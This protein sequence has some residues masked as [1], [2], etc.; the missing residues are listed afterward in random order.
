MN[1]YRK[2]VAIAFVLVVLLGGSFYTG[3]RVGE[4]RVKTVEIPSV[5]NKDSVIPVDSVDFSPFWKVWGIINDKFVPTVNTSTTT[6]QQRVWGAI[7]GLANSLKDPYTVFLPPVK[8]EIFQGDVRGNFQGVGMEVGLTEGV[9]TVIAPLKDTPAYKAGLKPGDKIVKIDGKSTL[10]LSTE[11]SVSL[12]RGEKG[13]TVVFSIVR[14]GAKESFD[15]PVVRDVI[16]IPTI[17]TTLRPDGIFVIELYSFSADSPELFRKALREFVES[18]TDK[19]LLD[20]R[21]NPGGYLEAAIDMASWFLPPGKIVVREDFG[22]KQE[23][24]IY[25]S[26]GY[27]IFNDKLKFVILVDGG[28]ASASEILAGALKEQHVAKLVGD[29]TFGKGSVQELVSITSDTSFKVTIARWLTPDGTSISVSGIMPAIQIKNKKE[30]LE[31]G[32][33]DQK[34]KAI[35]T[36]LNW[37]PIVNTGNAQSAN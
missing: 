32:V 31:K 8:N 1:A 6:D 20:L 29:K 24:T 13:T 4:K 28:S 9:L 16:N 27:D 19:L 5:L 23:Q 33:D 34:N 3:L 36:L 15:I 35:E 14:N 26:R 2:N 7:E 22:K 12:I 11:E 25:R 17:N 10:N 21:G 37:T 18:K 30:N